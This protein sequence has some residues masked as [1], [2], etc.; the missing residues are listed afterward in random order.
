MS[1]VKRALGHLLSCKEAS[2]K[3]SRAQDGPLSGFERWRL[4][5]HLAVCIACTRFERQL[6]FLREALQR[7]RT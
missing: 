3:L 6:R 4:R 2:R 5:M 7:Y 1:L